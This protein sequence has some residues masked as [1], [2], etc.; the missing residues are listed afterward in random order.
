MRIDCVVCLGDDIGRIVSICHVL[1]VWHGYLEKKI[2]ICCLY[3][4]DKYLELEI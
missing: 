4:S 2:C 1:F 3:C